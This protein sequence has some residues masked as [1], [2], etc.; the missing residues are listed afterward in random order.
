MAN[1]RLC[2][3]RVIRPVRFTSADLLIIHQDRAKELPEQVRTY[4]LATRT[5]LM[6]RATDL[7]FFTG[8]PLLF[9]TVS[10]DRCHRADFHG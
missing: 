4:D 8:V 6:T 10:D 1:T 9:A 7:N 5:G 3:A 2:V